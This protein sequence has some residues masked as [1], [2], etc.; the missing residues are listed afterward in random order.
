[1]STAYTTLITKLRRRLRD[2]AAEEWETA[3]LADYISDAERWLAQRLGGMR[4]SGRF[5]AQETLTLAADTEAY[6]TTT[7]AQQSFI[8]VQTIEK[9][10]PGGRY[11][12]VYQLNEGDQNL[13]RWGSTLAASEDYVPRY[14]LQAGSIHFLPKLKDVQ[15][16]II[17]HTWLPVRKTSGGTAETPEQYDDILILRAA[18][19][20]LGVTGNAE[21]TFEQK[22]AARLSEIED[23]EI[24]RENKGTSE[25]VQVKNSRLLFP[26]GGR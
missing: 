17:R 19:D 5:I 9:K 16:F 8:G 11:A 7:L 14:W 18:F 22:Y 2:S 4:K 10:M 23:F 21:T 12:P 25:T 24:N 15:T 20:S 26:M 13:G 6:D 3:E 1:M